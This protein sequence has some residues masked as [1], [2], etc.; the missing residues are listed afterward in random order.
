MA[1]AAMAAVTNVSGAFWRVIQVAK[2]KA[3]EAAMEATETYLVRAKRTIQIPRMIMSAP[4]TSAAS[5]PAEVAMPL[6]PRNLSQQV[7]LW[8]RIAASPAVILSGA[9]ATVPAGNQ[10]RTRS[11]TQAQAA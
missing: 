11:A 4:E 3:N 1:S 10:C 7:K 8:P 2:G 5:T 9:S 6:P